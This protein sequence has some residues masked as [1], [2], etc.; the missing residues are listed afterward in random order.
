MT[1]EGLTGLLVA[2]EYGALDVVHLL[3][4]RRNVNVLA[5]DE[6]HNT[7]LHHAIGHARVIELLTEVSTLHLVGLYGCS[8]LWRSVGL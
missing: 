8:S 6:K 4:V 2:S 5:L 3:I 1:L 7:V